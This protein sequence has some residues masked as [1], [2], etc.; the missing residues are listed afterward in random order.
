MHRGQ[1][2]GTA[3]P[4]SSESRQ[5]TEDAAGDQ[6]SDLRRQA[7]PRLFRERKRGQPGRG[8]GRGSCL[9]RDAVPGVLRNFGERSGTQER[10]P[11]EG[12][13]NIGRFWPRERFGLRIG[14]LRSARPGRSKDQRTFG[15]RSR[16]E[17]PGSSQE[18]T[19]RWEATPELVS[20]D[21]ERVDGA[22]ASINQ[23]TNTGRSFARRSGGW[24]QCRPPFLLG[25]CRARLLV[26]CA[27]P[28]PPD[29]SRSGSLVNFSLD[30]TG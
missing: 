4:A 14:N 1:V 18:G 17:Q 28:T 8:A 13:Q 29:S 16:V 20:Q 9:S 5:R 15:R 30:R 6:R 25:Q 7:L 10:F 21:R 26:D 3:V 23:V 22:K 2:I 11:Q 27:P 12:P 19:A 24:Q